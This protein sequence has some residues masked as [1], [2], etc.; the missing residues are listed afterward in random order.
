M[1][2]RIFLT[3]I[4]SCAVSCKEFIDCR[5]VSA[6]VDWEFWS[7]EQFRHY[8]AKREA[9]PELWPTIPNANLERPLESLNGF[10]VVPRTVTFVGSL[11]V[12]KQTVEHG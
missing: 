4:A 8:P 11:L 9:N 2:V 12:P 3:R 6:A 7:I 5:G 1:S 10:M